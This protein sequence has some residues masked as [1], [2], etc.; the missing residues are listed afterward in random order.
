MSVS[1]KDSPNKK[2]RYIL[3]KIQNHVIDKD[4]IWGKKKQNSLQSIR[5]VKNRSKKMGK[6]YS[7]QVSYENTNKWQ[8][9]VCEDIQP[10][11]T[12][13]TKRQ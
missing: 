12:R 9:S 3:E 8:I 10:E 5:K 4:R 2:A 6:V 7:R 11:G 1:P 13:E